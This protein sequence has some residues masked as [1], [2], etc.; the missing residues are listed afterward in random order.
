MS[1]FGS[2]IFNLFYDAMKGTL[3]KIRQETPKFVFYA[4]FS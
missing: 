2:L 1:F 3:S 4:I